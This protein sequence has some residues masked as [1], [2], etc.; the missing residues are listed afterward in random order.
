[1]PRTLSGNNGS[2]VSRVEAVDRRRSCWSVRSCLIGIL[3]A[4]VHSLI[5]EVDINPMYSRFG[6][7]SEI[8]NACTSKS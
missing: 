7:L 4:G 8:L 2:V 5:Q 3:H 1:M 6:Q